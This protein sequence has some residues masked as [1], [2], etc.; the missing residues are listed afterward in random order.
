[1][2]NLQSR[3]KVRLLQSFLLISLSLFFFVNPA[4]AQGGF[5]VKELLWIKQDFLCL[6]PM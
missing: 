6:A 2:K 3:T 4:Y 5:A 1:M